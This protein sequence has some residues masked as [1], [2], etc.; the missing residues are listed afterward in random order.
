M[1]NFKP[2]TS[3]SLTFKLLDESGQVLAPTSLSFR[4]LNEADVELQPLTSIPVPSPA[5]LEVVIVVL[6]ALTGLT[7]PALRAIRTVELEVTTLS[8]TVVLTQSLMVQ[9]STALALGVN[10]FQT[11]TQAL[12]LS[13]DFVQ[14]QMSGWTGFQR[15]DR[16][17]ALI[18]AFGRLLL[19]PIYPYVDSNNQSSL[20][21]TD[22]LARNFG[23]SLM[24]NLR[25]DQLIALQPKLLMAL[26]KAQLF[27]AD[28][29][30]NDDPAAKARKSGIS[31]LT[32]GESTTIFRQGSPLNLQVGSRAVTY[33]QPWLRFSAR[34]GRE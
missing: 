25:S 26:R 7:P 34:I 33:L 22:S 13:E 21:Q 12:L 18:E 3:V 10:T 29:I 31:S 17:K 5:S 11:Y 23:Y 4:I 1:Q 28:D 2:G 9:G 24:R 20:T 32:V 8:G 6:A 30:L 19:L 16:E 15:E 27:E 14:D